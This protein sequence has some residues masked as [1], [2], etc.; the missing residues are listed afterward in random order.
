MYTGLFR[1]ADEET[2]PEPHEGAAQAGIPQKMDKSYH[3][4]D[5]IAN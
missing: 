2:M 5:F 3:Q 1:Q 4:I